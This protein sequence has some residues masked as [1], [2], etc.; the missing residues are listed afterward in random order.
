[1]TGKQPP[2]ARWDRKL[3]DYP[4]P[5]AHM[6]RQHTLVPRVSF[7]AQVAAR[8]ASFA[9]TR[10]AVGWGARAS[11]APCLPSRQRVRPGAMPLR[12][13]ERQVAV[14]RQS[15]AE[16]ER[17]WY[18]SNA[19]R[20]HRA[21]ERTKAYR[22][23]SVP[24]WEQVHRRGSAWLCGGPAAIG[25]RVGRIDPEELGTMYTRSALQ[26]APQFSP[27]A[28]LR[29]RMEQMRERSPAAAR[30]ARGCAGAR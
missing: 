26:G 29:Q 21:G 17:H 8:E 18:T 27:D 20:A 6:R 7:P 23:Q 28:S 4:D 2:P 15:V 16:R 3:A 14:D 1:M 10:A 30:H 5:T 11:S 13:E 22:P 19:M 25:A 9:G 24:V 12:D